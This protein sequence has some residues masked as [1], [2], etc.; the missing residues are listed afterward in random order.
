MAKTFHLKFCFLKERKNEEHPRFTLEERSGSKCFRCAHA[1]SFLCNQVR[2]CGGGEDPVGK[3]GFHC[4]HPPQRGKPPAL[5]T[6][7]AIGGSSFFMGVQTH[8]F[9]FSRS[10]SLN[11]CG[12]YRRVVWPH[13][14][15]QLPFLGRKGCRLQNS[16]W[17]WEP[18]Q[19]SGP[20]RT[21]PS[22]TELW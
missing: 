13:Y 22:S 14:T 20:R 19:T 7:I 5:I 8:K 2:W 18:T 3:R 17:R 12:V 9:T 15:L 6:G 16:F 11:S 4:H 21:T 10:L 1:C